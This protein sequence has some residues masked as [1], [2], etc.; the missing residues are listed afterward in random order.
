MET[1]IL[2]IVISSAVLL[3]F[4]H[5][6]LAKERI[7]KFNRIFLVSSLLFAYSLPFIPMPNYF[8]SSNQPNLIFGEPVQQFQQVGVNTA[9]HFDWSNLILGVYLS[10]STLFLVKFI[11]S[12]LKI[13]LLKGE[14][15]IYK[16]QRIVV[17][18][19]DYAPFSF[20]KTMYFGE[21][22]IVDNQIDERIF[23][24]EKCHAS[25]NH[26]ADIL[27]IEFLK[28]F[29]WFN[30]ALYFYK[31]AMII[32]HEFLADEFVLNNNYEISKY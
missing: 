8:E 29:S 32:N 31:N 9:Q 3:G 12:F 23:L 16:D 24:H 22:H 15:R 20:L 27:L 28:I 30:P 5:F 10:I 1:I 17:L 19:Q 6:F 14:K 11:H 18:N 26:T 21:K 4:Y 7:F 25:Q 13:K 2:K